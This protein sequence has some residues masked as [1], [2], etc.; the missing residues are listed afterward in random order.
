LNHRHECCER[1]YDLSRKRTIAERTATPLGV[2]NDDEDCP[3]MLNTKGTKFTKEKT[4]ESQIDEQWIRTGQA[5]GYSLRPKA[6]GG[7]R[8]PGCAGK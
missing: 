8:H 6:S 5:I 7:F 2:G 4:F 1:I 3:I